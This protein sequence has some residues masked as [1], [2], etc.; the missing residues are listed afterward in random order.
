MDKSGFVFGIYPGGAAGTDQ[1]MTYAGP[2][3][4]PAE[5][6]AA[7]NRLQGDKKSLLV[8]TYLTYGG[9]GR[10]K[11]LL[12]E[13]PLQYAVKGRKIDLVIGY[14]PQTA[15]LVDWT[16]FIVAQIQLYAPYLS[17]VQVC[18]EPNLHGIPGIDGDSPKVREALMQGVIAAKR[19]IRQNGWNI[20]VGFNTVPNFDPS[21]DFWRFLGKH[22]SDEFYDSLDY[23]GFD[24]FPDVFRPVAEDKL[25]EAVGAVITHY[26]EESRVEGKIPRHLPVHI[27]ENGWATSP[28]RSYE[29]QALVIEKI[30]RALYDL[31]SV[32][33]LTHYEMFDLR[34]ADSSN[35]DFFYQFGLMKDDYTPKPAFCVFQNLI[36]ELGV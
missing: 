1:G 29:K 13:N 35:P 22:A 28:E 32:F 4:Q 8:R 31:K 9:N 23:T 5:I 18:E 11:H 2:A 10:V 6:S 36:A 3:N 21:N 16:K 12:P 34:D 27:T 19:V 26:M 15:D 30:I 20:A 24:F 25:A 14:Q 33:P 7:L 17:K